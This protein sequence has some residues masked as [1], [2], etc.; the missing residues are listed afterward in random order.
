MLD[1]LARYSFLTSAGA[2]HVIKLLFQLVSMEWDGFGDSSIQ[3]RLILPLV[4][5]T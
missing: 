1:R 3:V 4:A 2:V 5:T